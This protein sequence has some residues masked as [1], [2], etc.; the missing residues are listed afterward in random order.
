MPKKK[1]KSR[2]EEIVEVQE[3]ISKKSLP[4]PFVEPVTILSTDLGRG[5]L[6]ELR[7]KIN[8]V[9]NRFNGR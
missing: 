5:D 2:Y 1:A 8:E 9:I 7:D 6:N 3:E 4:N